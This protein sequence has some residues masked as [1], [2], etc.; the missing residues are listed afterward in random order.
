M[1]S[2][3]DLGMQM[4]DAVKAYVGRSMHSFADRIDAIESRAPVAGPPGTDGKDGEGIQ[5]PP[6]PAGRDVD[7]EAVRGMIGEAVA[8]AWNQMP[9]PQDGAPGKD[10]ESVEAEQVQRMVDDI[11]A[12]AMASIPK[13]QNGVDGAKGEAGRDGKDAPQLEILSGVDPERRYARNTYARHAGG[14][15]RAFRDTDAINL[16]EVEKSGWEVVLNGIAD[17]SEEISE[18]GRTIIKTTRYTSGPPWVRSYQTGSIQYQGIYVAEKEYCKGD[19]VTWGGE[20]WY[21]KEDKTTIEPKY[22][23]GG[24]SPWQ[25]IAKKGRDGKDAKGK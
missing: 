6:G 4:L 22:N 14:L 1:A 7:M 24:T 3:K 23:H 5:G 25:L 11:V 13:P 20:S 2:G 8:V 10:G 15:I 9:K 17:E 21:C 18:D 12:S 16:A 19:V